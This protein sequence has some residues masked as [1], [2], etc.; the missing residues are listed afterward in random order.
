MYHRIQNADRRDR[1]LRT[2]GGSPPGNSEPESRTRSRPEAR[3]G[4]D[5]SAD[6]SE[7][8]QRTDAQSL[9][10]G[11]VFDVLQ[12]RRRRDVLWHLSTVSERVSISDLA[13]SIAA[14]ECGKPVEQLTTEERKRVYISLYQGHLP[15]M[16]DVGAVTYDQGRG[17][18]E[19]GPNFTRFTDHLPEEDKPTDD[20]EGDGSLLDRLSGFLE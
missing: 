8:S 1:S 16:T 2:D 10:I 7:H 20:D 11:T 6:A 3:E 9:D 12:N 13:E 15:K 19:R 18:V 17:I 5:Q 4:D 14:W